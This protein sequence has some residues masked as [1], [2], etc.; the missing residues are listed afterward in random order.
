MPRLF[1]AIKIQPQEKLLNTL[2]IIHQSFFRDEIKWVNPENMHITLK[3]LG[4]TPR[5]DIPLIIDRLKSI[6]P[7]LDPFE[8]NIRKFGYFGNLRFPRVLWLGIDQQGNPIGKAYQKI[9]TQMIS[10][11]YTA[12]KQVFK[13]HLT[14]GRVKK[15]ENTQKL[16]ELESELD[17]EV[18]QQVSIDSFELYKS[19]LTPNGPVYSVIEKFSLI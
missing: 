11:G 10:L 8:F 6:A 1:I 14:I 15:T 5:E 2:N 12:E 18:L 3:F 4:D 13:P 16:R 19:K 7:A 17:D 9:Q